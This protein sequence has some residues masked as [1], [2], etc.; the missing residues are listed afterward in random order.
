MIVPKGSICF[1]GLKADTTKR[2][3]GVVAKKMRYEAMRS[4]MESYG[5]DHRH[6]PDR[7]KIYCV[8]AHSVDF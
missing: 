4:L 2:P 8:T 1:A 6:R 7:R 3:R 5:D